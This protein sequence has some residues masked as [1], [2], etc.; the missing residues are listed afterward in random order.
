MYVPAKKGKHEFSVVVK[1]NGS[2]DCEAMRLLNI[3]FTQYDD[4]LSSLFYRKS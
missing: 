2:P 1:N 4:Y 3:E